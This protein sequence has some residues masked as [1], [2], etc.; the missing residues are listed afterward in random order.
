MGPLPL[1][2]AYDSVI[3]PFQ[4]GDTILLQRLQRQA[5]K[6]NLV[7]SLLRPRSPSWVALSALLPWDNAGN[8]TYVLHQN[9]HGLARAGFLQAQR[10]PGR[11]EADVLSLAPALDTRTGHP[12]I[13]EK[14]LAHYVTEEAGGQTLRIYADVPDQ[15]LLVNTFS[16]IGFSVYSRLTVWR[17]V[18]GEGRS[19]VPSARAELRPVQRGDEWELLRLYARSTPMPVQVAEGAVGD[20]A[21]NP[22]ILAWWN[23]GEPQ[24]FVLQH[25]DEL[26]GC[27]RVV[28]EQ[29]GIWM[30]FWADPHYPQLEVGRHL[31][32]I[33]LASV[34]NHDERLPLYVAVKD[35]QGGLGPML[36]DFGFAPFAD[37]ARMVKHMVQRVVE[38]ETVRMGA[39]EVV[40]EVLV[41][42]RPL[43]ESQK[44]VSRRTPAA[45][46]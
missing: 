12:A 45:L 41:T 10:R 25:R 30:Q 19:F 7:Q 17:L 15:P 3:R 6:L 22:P 37:Y 40:P 44:G 28:S 1:F 29:A 35:Y 39:V 2:G 4:P 13:W 24:S 36:N 8:T 46:R 31:L 33:A 32:S 23:G 16:H 20:Q 9:G 11:N 18:S 5:T 38:T 42:F 26:V 34:R 14:L 27:V 21:N 43:E